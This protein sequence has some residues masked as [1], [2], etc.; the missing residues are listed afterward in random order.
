MGKCVVSGCPN[1]IVPYNRFAPHR[2]ARR[3][4]R[5][6]KDPD[7]VKVWLAALRESDKDRSEQHVI[8]E[9]HFLP[10]DISKTGVS[11]DAIPLMPPYL[12]GPGGLFSPWSTEALQEEEQWLAGGCEEEGEEE[13]GPDPQE[14]DP[15]GGAESPAEPQKTRD[16]PRAET[17][18]RMIKADTPLSLLTRGFL[19]L[20]MASPD[21]VV[22]IEAVAASLLTST[23]RVYNIVS[24]LRG[25]SMVQRMGTRV[26]GPDWICSFLFRNPLRF[27][28]ALEKL[29]QVENKLDHLIRT[30]AEQL[31]SLTDDAQ[32]AA[33]AYVTLEDIARLR[34][35]Q[36]QTVIVVKAPRGTKLNVPPPDQRSTR[37]HLISEKNPIVALTCEVGS[38]NPVTSDPAA[39]GR[40]FSE[41]DKSRIKIYS[42]HRVPEMQRAEVRKN[43]V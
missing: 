24:V 25:L 27:L 8:C 1:R 18:G 26:K 38:Q 37:M 42:L 17:S 5:F 2:P 36:E 9:D 23:R 22:D 11:S 28:V 43:Q 14:Q 16:S 29:K 12:D 40:S 41:L 31:F 30:C 33:S 21:R 20:V 4:F 15:D 13:A 32:S 10:E 3:F 35:L 39:D 19:E 34:D 7:R 6:P